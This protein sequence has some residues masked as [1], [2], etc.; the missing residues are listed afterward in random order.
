M[1][2]PHTILLATV[3]FSA[4]VF[5]TAQTPQSSKPAPKYDTA[6]EVTL[7]GVIAETTDRICPVSGGL[8]FH[9][10]LKQADGKLIEVHV[11]TTKFV[12][13]YE[14]SL[15]RG[16]DVKVVG[17]KVQMDGVDTILAREVVRGNET[18]A[19]R[20]KDGKPAW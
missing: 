3:L 19:F 9:F 4:C 1:K 18:L 15:K 5:A 2:S 14:L 20:D 8:G 13:D 7:K 11:S 12:K 6:T 17:S 10:M 16:D